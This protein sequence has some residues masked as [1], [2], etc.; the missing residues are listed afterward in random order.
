[1]DLLHL[2]IIIS[3]EQQAKQKDHKGKIVASTKN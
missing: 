2:I 3:R 1:M